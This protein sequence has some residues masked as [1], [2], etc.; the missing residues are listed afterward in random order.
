MNA[1]K[2]RILIVEDQRLIAVD[3][4][5]TLQR[6]GYEVV[7]KA[8]RGDEAIAKASE[9]LPDLVLMDI[10]LEGDMDGIQAAEA[11]RARTDVPVVYLTAFA[12]DETIL[13]AKTTSPFGYVVKPFDEREL[14]AAIE[15][16]VYKHETDRLIA[17]ERAR[18]RTAEEFKLFVQ[19]VKDY[20]IF[21]IDVGGRVSTW[22]EGAR[23]I[24][25]YRTEEILGQHFSI[26]YPP[27]DVERGRPKAALDV[28][29]ETGHA[30]HEGWLVRK[31]GSRFWAHVVVT[32]IRDERGEL[33]GFG[34]VT[35]DLDE[36]R[37][38]DD[39]RER[40]IGDL[41]EA[42]RSRDEFIQI[43]SHELRTPLGPLQLQL[44]M[45]A[46]LLEK[47]GV[48]GERI[49]D[50]LAIATRQTVRLT[51][52]VESMLDV[53]RI[54]AGR[55]TLDPEGVDVEGLVR[56]VVERFGEAAEKAGSRIDVRAEPS[57]PV[58]W[59]RIRVE[60]ILSNLLAN[61]IR[62]GSG[63][64]IGIETRVDAGTI[65]ISIADRGIGIEVDAVDRIF[66][67]FER[68]VSL[69]HFGGLGLGLY[70][71][72]QLAQAHGGNILVEST[73]GAGSTFTVTLP[74]E[75]SPQPSAAVGEEG[76]TA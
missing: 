50:M 42:V 72:K 32:P 27:E 54:S 38:A 8:G 49:S 18:R 24:K 11:I 12:D 13:R 23:R 34:K 35:R 22:N 61:A 26:F 45:F 4:E 40:L 31:D 56:D 17:E 30:E 41:Q 29:L 73:P 39:E 70:I 2:K 63:K 10:R 6:M 76:P 66:G 15:V 59:D 51:R 52:L 53:S 9:I 7:A 3:I 28:A 21:M 71:A 75:V 16:A 65:R 44:D 5:K 69:R 47:S 55:I 33:R 25:G 62:Y 20:A 36:K 37:R 43:A 48:K 57:P 67:R 64:P 1:P 19:A 74:I 68:A 60:Q 14:R 58:R 46:H